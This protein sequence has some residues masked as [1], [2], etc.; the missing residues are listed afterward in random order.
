[1]ADEQGYARLMAAAAPDPVGFWERLMGPASGAMRSAGFG[2][3]DP[4]VMGQDLAGAAGHLATLPQR[5]MGSAANFERTGQYDPAPIVE[6]TMMLAGGASPFAVRGAAGIFGG[7]LAQ[8]ADHAALAKAEQMATSGASRDAIWKDTGWFKGA[9]DKWRFEIPDKAAVM[10][11]ANPGSYTAGDVISHPEFFKAYPDVKTLP[12]ELRDPNVGGA[13]GSYTPSDPVL[14]GLG[15]EEGFMA[16][17]APDARESLLHEMQHSVQSREGFSQGSTPGAFT[18]Q[19]DAQLARDALSFRREM[20]ALPKGMDSHAKENAIVEQ[21]RQ[22]G[23]MDWLPSYAARDLA[24]DLAGNSTAELEKIVKFYGL[25]KRTTPLSGMQ[26][27]KSVPGEVEARNVQTRMDMTPAERRAAP[28]WTT[29]D[30]TLW[31]GL[32]KAD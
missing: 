19:K 29:E 13:R 26:L 15:V 5:A 10:K 23:A 9:D 22:L 12:T 31:Q 20:E 7:K 1:M 24:H 4:A 18:Q 2:R 27:Y 32:M 28:P 3:I 25:D 17:A 6:S 30:A 21:Y 16:K 11:E 8:T 14:K